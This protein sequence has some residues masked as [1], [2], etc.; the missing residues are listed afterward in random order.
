[1]PIHEKNLIEE[2]YV[3]P[4]ILQAYWNDGCTVEHV[5]D[6]IGNVTVVKQK[7]EKLVK[8]DVLVCNEGVIRLTKSGLAIGKHLDAA[9]DILNS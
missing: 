7:I 1:M 3:I 5:C 2:D 4:I 8:N 9:A 6:E